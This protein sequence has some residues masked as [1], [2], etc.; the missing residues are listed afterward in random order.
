MPLNPF[1]RA[2]FRSTIPTHC[3]PV[4]DYVLLVPTT[5]VLLHSRDRETNQPYAELAQSEEFLGSHVLRA[6]KDD[7]ANGAAI[8]AARENRGKARQYSTSNGRTLIIK[9]TWV[10]THKGFRTLNQAQLQH[11]VLY[12]PNSIDAQPWLIYYISRPLI[13][14]IEHVPLVIKPKLPLP[15]I[16]A[17]PSTAAHVMPKKK[18]IRDFV[19]LLEAFPMIARQLQ[20]GL[21]SLFQELEMSIPELASTSA[22]ASSV[23]SPR[24]SSNGASAPAATSA[25]AA[26]PATSTDTTADTESDVPPPLPARPPTWSVQAAIDEATMR[27]T[28]ETAIMAAI[29]LFQ[30]V[31]HS[32]LQLLATTTELTGPSI[33]HLIER[34]ICE[35]LHDTYIFPLLLRLKKEENAVLDEKIKEMEHIDI[36]QVGISVPDN[37]TRRNLAERV[38]RAVDKFERISDA[39]SPQEMLD[40][41]LETAQALT[42][43]EQE[44]LA[45]KRR[46]SPYR[47]PLTTADAPASSEKPSDETTNPVLTMNADMLVSLLLIVVIRA[48]VKGLQSCLSYMRNFVFV[49]EVEAGERGY[50]L[51]TLEG[52]LFHITMDSEHMGKASKRNGRLWDRIR[53]GN[54]G[55][56]RTLLERKEDLAELDNGALSPVNDIPDLRFVGFDDEQGAKSRRA[57]QKKKQD[58]R[59]AEVNGGLK[60]V[61]AEVNGVL[62]SP[63]MD[64]PEAT[65]VPEVFAK[66]ESPKDKL[67]ELIPELELPENE[68]DDGGSE[69]RVLRVDE[70]DMEMDGPGDGD[71]A[72]EHPIPPEVAIAAEEALKETLEQEQQ[73][74]QREEQELQSVEQEDLT[75]EQDPD[76]DEHEIQNDEPANETSAVAEIAETLAEEAEA[77]G[78]VDGDEGL[79]LETEEDA[80]L[81]LTGEAAESLAEST[82][83]TSI[84]G[85]TKTEELPK[86]KGTMKTKFNPEV[87]FEGLPMHPNK[88]LTRS[89]SVRSDMSR[90]SW[91]SSS[92]Y[93]L[94]HLSHSALSLS[95]DLMSLEVLSKTQNVRG[96]SIVMMAV[97]NQQQDDRSHD[98]TTLLSAA[99]QGENYDI[100]RVIMEELMKASDE[101]IHGYMKAVD[102]NGRTAGHYAFK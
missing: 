92:H 26:E 39:R 77:D 90:N 4:S 44:V 71:M 65:L 58:K 73:E 84:D 96:E 50:V 30:R 98:G 54:V 31:D 69:P 76:T 2:F 64:A 17:E 11:D 20:P 79:E 53:K 35:R 57:I 91:A 56:V 101:E 32:Q 68:D 100:V 18:E 24:L 16:P 66:I 62:L 38:L 28:T 99:I 3:T 36:A 93:S 47:T 8:A 67:P 49:D 74:T 87:L 13:G 63:N 37:E 29:E 85:E 59:Q 51:S 89:T 97:I 61:E 10:Y 27:T 94:E 1:L 80:S 48:R 19:D 5:D 72:D 41:L 46:D 70:R 14:S 78:S 33:E 7:V 52:V 9:E 45:K 15:P 60:A 95:E 75:H 34:Y 81:T 43:S 88:K 21:K 55:G 42:Q 40:I 6:S 102:S 83:A 22:G 86:L 82:A 23:S 12:W 25:P